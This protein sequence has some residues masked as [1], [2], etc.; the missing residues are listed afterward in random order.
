MPP[1]EHQSF[2]VQH[3]LNLIMSGESKTT[4]TLSDN[5]WLSNKQTKQI[6]GVLQ[7]QVGAIFFGCELSCFIFKPVET[8][9]ALA[10]FSFFK[11]KI[12]HYFG[13]FL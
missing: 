1:P 6:S 8:D 10:A 7:Y 11:Q 9:N 12:A 4:L 2:E 5:L 3:Y 13:S